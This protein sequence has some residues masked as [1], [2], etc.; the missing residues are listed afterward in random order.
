MTGDGLAMLRAT[1]LMRI[2]GGIVLGPA[3][4]AEAHKMPIEVAWVCTKEG[5]VAKRGGLGCLGLAEHL[6]MLNEA[7]D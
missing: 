7:D 3:V 6:S 4:L 1:V 2:S 5:G